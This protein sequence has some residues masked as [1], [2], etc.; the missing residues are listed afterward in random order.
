MAI[1]CIRMKVLGVGKKT[2][3]HG[4]A[5]CIRRNTQQI[6]YE[7]CMRAVLGGKNVCVVKHM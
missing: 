7:S 5:D 2:E 6:I 3:E 4:H 1:G